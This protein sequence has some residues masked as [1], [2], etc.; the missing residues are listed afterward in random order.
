M[1][2]LPI[3]TD[4]LILRAIE[5]SDADGL[6][7]L[8]SNPRVH[9]F[10]GNRPIKRKDE[11]YAII[12]YIHKQYSDNGIGRWAMIE[13]A[14]GEFMGW[15]GIKIESKETNGYTDYCD[16]GYRMIPRFWGKGYATESS[17]VAVDYGFKVLDISTIYGAAHIDN[18]ASNKVLQKAGLEFVNCFEYEGQMHN[19]YALNQQK[20]NSQT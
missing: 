20:W 5:A 6:F 15:T 16:L 19:W 13:K 9:Q 14:S 3:E 12:D 2:G 18:I 1:K 8:D 11:V 4:R 10:L 17:L 7:E